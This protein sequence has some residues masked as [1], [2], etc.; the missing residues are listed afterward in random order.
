MRKVIFIG[1]CALDILFSGSLGREGALESVAIPGGRMLNASALLGRIGADV[2]FVGEVARDAVGRLIL[3]FLEANGVRTQSIDRFTGGVTPLNVYIPS[4]D[5]ASTDDVVI[6]RQ[7]PAEPF[8]AVWPRID[9]DDI[10]VFGTFFSLDA[11]VRPLLQELLSHVNE[12][13]GIVIYLPGFL[14][15]QAPRITKVM[16][17]ILENLEASDIVFT[18]TSDVSTIFNLTQPKQCYDGHV[19]FYVSSYINAGEGDITY[20]YGNTQASVGLEGGSARSLM[21]HSGALAGLISALIDNDVTKASLS[22]L[23]QDVMKR[24]VDKMEAAAS[25]AA[26]GAL[27]DH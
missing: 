17:A 9:P 22:H 27:T 19:K 5:G 15:S 14:P 3:D 12:R 24:I 7:S 4:G 21:W 16:P 6:Y 10:V 11:R 18:R 8:D 23:D 13:R 2:T 26:A 20:Y 1:E 25:G